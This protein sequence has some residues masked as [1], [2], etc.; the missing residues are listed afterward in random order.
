MIPREK[1][2]QLPIETLRDLN[3]VVVDLIKT[4]VATESRRTAWKLQIGDK[5]SYK[6]RAGKVI[7]AKVTEI[8]RVNVVVQHLDASPYDPT[9]FPR[10]RMKASSLTILREA[11]TPSAVA[12]DLG[13][14][15]F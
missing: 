5:V 14:P 9:H 10:W 3:R 7:H 2:A 4:K 11:N 6:D 12:E 1:L 8:G 15:S 13:I